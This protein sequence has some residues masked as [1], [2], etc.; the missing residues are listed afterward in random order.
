MQIEIMVQCA[1]KEAGALVR[2]DKIKI[3]EVEKYT[4]L[5][6]TAMIGIVKNSNGVE[7]VQSSSSNNNPM[8]KNP[9]EPASDAQKKFLDDLIGQLP[10]S[11]Q[12]KVTIKPNITKGEI[13]ILIE[14]FKTRAK[15]QKNKVYENSG[16]YQAPF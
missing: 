6:T 10:K 15:A 14:T 12:D 1:L 16:T 13:S 4:G 7:T 11:E 8:I 3:D 2:A 9:D 5:F